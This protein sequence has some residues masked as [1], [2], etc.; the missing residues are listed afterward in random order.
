MLEWDARE[1]ST[2]WYW[3]SSHHMMIYFNIDPAGVHHP[4]AR[5]RRAIIATSLPGERAGVDLIS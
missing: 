3:I 2:E 4:M 1:L 5:N